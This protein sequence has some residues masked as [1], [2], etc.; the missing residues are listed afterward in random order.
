MMTQ[1]QIADALGLSCA[2]VAN[3]L[4]GNPRL[5][6]SKETRDRV[7]KAAA[8]MGYQQNRASRVIRTGRSNLVGIVHFGS[9]IEA[10]RRSHSALSKYCHEAGFQYYGVDMTW[11]A[12]SVDRTLSELIQARVEGVII[13]HVQEVFQDKHIEILHKAGI[14]VVSLN[15]EKRK[16][17]PLVCDNIDKAFYELTHHLLRIGHR[18]ILHLLPGNALHFRTRG[19]RAKGFV[20]AIKEVGKLKTLTEEEFFSRKLPRTRK[21]SG[22]TGYLIEQDPKLYDSVDKPVYRFCKQLF[23]KGILPDAIMC[24]N[25]MYAIEAILAGLECGIRVPDDIAV[26]GYDNDRLGAYPAFGL[27][28]AEQ[29]VERL[30][31]TAVSTLQEWIKKRLLGKDADTQTYD[32]KIIIRTSCGVKCHS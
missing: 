11:H 8:E 29:D 27:T 31:A 13:A 3:I 23:S 6:Y 30:C 32:S 14:P 12:G 15:G 22:I 1:R 16:N 24:P 21:G 4:S 25:D 5:R 20:R 9:D 10:A 2:T 26:T 18:Q 19:M 28:T 7:I 17:V